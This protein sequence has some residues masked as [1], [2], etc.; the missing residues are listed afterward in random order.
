MCSV[1]NDD[2]DQ[3]EIMGRTG[4]GKSSML[5]CLL[6]L[7]DISKGSITIDGTNIEKLELLELRSNISVISQTPALIQGTMRHNLNIQN[8]HSD[9]ELWNVLSVVHLKERLSSEGLQ[10]KV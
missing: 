10:T 4:A 5:G 2:P 8:K 9:V 3:I 1:G 6:R 7:M